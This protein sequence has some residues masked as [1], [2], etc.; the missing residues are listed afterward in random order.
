MHQCEPHVE[1][2]D[3]FEILG[4]ARNSDVDQLKGAYHALCKD[5]HPDRMRGLG[6]PAD[7]VALANARLVRIIDAYRRVLDLRNGAAGN[8]RPVAS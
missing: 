8:G 5:Y 7:I 2:S 6:L 1:T 4:I 3:P